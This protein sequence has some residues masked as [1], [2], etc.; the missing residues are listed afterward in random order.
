MFIGWLNFTVLA[1]V[2]LLNVE[3]VKPQFTANTKTTLEAKV[4]HR[5]MGNIGYYNR[6]LL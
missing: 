5:K 1:L 3:D 4:F 2:L 6:L